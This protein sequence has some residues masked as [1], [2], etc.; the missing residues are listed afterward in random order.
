MDM[1]KWASKLLLGR[2]MKSKGPWKANAHITTSERGIARHKGAEV[3][4]FIAKL[5]NVELDENVRCRKNPKG[6]DETAMP[7]GGTVACAPRPPCF[8]CSS[9]ALGRPRRT[10]LKS[11]VLAWRA[12]W[13]LHPFQIVHWARDSS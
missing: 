5:P 6:W 4:V 11:Q 10:R 3:A 2:R 9:V 1:W 12:E 7:L 8:L 13:R